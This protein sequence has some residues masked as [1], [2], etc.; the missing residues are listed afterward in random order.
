MKKI[1]VLFFVFALALAACGTPATEA[2]V[3]EAAPVPPNAVIAE[4]HIKP[5][6]AANLS[7]QARGIVEQVH[8]K[9]GDQVSAGDVLARLSNASQAEAGL[10][11]AKLELLDA[12]QSL[13]SLNR[14]GGA[15]LAAAWSAYMDAQKS[16][17]E[18]ERK[19][20]RLDLDA[21]DDRIED[22]KTD[23]ADRAE[24]LADAQAD[25]DK[26]KDLDKDNSRRKTAEDELE[27]AQEDYNEAA[28]KLEEVTRERDA[29]RAAL[30]AAL[31][32]EAEASR[33]YEIST[34][35]VNKDQ[36]A[37]AE[38][39]L[40]NAQAQ[41]AA[42]EAALDNYILRAPFDGQ[43]ADVA[44]SAGE[45]VGPEA[46][47][48]SVIDA[49]AWVVETSDVTELEVVDLA[50]GQAASFVPDALPGLKLDGVV[51]AISRSSHLQSGDVLYTVYV[52]VKNADPRVL[53]GMTV[54]I[55]FEPME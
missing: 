40:E 4:G 32:A 48:V 22:A 18:A 24:D 47:A 38:A 52:T 12:Q 28:R 19:W 9:I 43:V 33:Q 8:V 5:V 1:I 21:V 46:R 36:L 51:A 16:R 31:A 11:A 7:F 14:T 13:D 50:V 30:D 23:L 44:V 17:A 29:V 20:E 42:A 27:T 45:Q 3:A 2:P 55:T 37:L 41:V 39:R 25:F 34:G 54:E 26:Y 10:A 49:S 35:G 53:W 15:N 6:R